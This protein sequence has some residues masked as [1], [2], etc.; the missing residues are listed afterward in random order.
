MFWK[1]IKENIQIAVK[2]AAEIDNCLS[3]YG[4]YID[5]DID[6]ETAKRNYEAYQNDL[7]Q[8]QADLIKKWCREI[9]EASKKGEKFIYTN[10]FVTDDDK[11]KILYAINGAGCCCEFPPNATLQYFQRYFEERGFK[12]VK[13]KYP[14]NNICRLKIFWV[15]SERR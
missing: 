10:D 13:I 6:A 5:C 4:S 11:D 3:N 7:I 12:V 14:T 9:N 1:K 2:D 15:Y 8:R